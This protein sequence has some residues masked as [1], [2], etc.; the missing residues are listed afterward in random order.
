MRRYWLP[1]TFTKTM[2][3]TADAQYRQVY[4]PVRVA[5]ELFDRLKRHPP[6]RL[7]PQAINTAQEWLREI[8][9]AINLNGGKPVA[10]AHKRIQDRFRKH[11][12]PHTTFR[13]ALRDIGLITLT[14]YR[15]S[16]KAG[17][18]GEHRTFALTA[19]GRRLVRKS[20]YQWLCALFN[21]PK[22]RRKNQVAVAVAKHR[23]P[24]SGYTD[25]AL[26]AID[27]FRRGV[28]FEHTDLLRALKL[29]KSVLAELK[30]DMTARP[31][32]A[33]AALPF[34]LAIVRRDFGPLERR[35]G[36]IDYEFAS[37]PAKYRRFAVFNGRP[38]AAS[39]GFYGGH[40]SFLGKMLNDAYQRRMDGPS[41]PRNRSR[42]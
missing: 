5:R 10:L 37:L 31:A 23:H 20:N 24:T 16:Q 38:Y 17:V 3:G 36:K 21:D 27:A 26:Q 13:D 30:W 19:L 1:A 7:E 15:P 9:A 18:Q 29:D 2:N 12:Q 4:D 42:S 33:G 11:T 28:T 35:E 22:V 34:L 41:F 32:M 6:F 39:L 14:G 40:V 8:D 25:A